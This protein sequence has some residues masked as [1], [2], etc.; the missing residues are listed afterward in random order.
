MNL[1][2]NWQEQD[3]TCHFCGTKKSVKYWVRAAVGNGWVPSRIDNVPCCNKCAIT[4]P[5]L[6]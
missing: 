4:R 5:V 3:L 1:I 2:P 6:R